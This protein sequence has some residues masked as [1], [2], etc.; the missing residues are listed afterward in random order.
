MITEFNNERLGRPT[1]L[2]IESDGRRRRRLR[3]ALQSD[4]DAVEA[5]NGVEGLRVFERFSERI[6]AVVTRLDLP[7]LNGDLVADWIH[8]LRP[9][10]PIIV[11]HNGLA[12]NLA[13]LRSDERTEVIC[14]PRDPHQVGARLKELIH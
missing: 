3:S 9:E 5:A 1:I 8:R 14:R 13:V 4:Y 7:R 12:A 10:L 2:L 11:L 6:R